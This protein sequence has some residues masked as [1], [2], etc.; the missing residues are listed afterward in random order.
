MNVKPKRVL[1]VGMTDN[2]GGIEALMLNA[3]AALDSRDIQFDFLANTDHMAFEEQLIER[4]SQVHRITA[5]RKSRSMFYRELNDLLERTRGTYD[6]IWENMNTL[7]NIDY[8]IHAKRYGIPVR[9]IHCHSS[10][11]C[12]GLVRGVLHLGNRRRIRKY[13][14]HFW[15]VSNEASE[16]FYG[17]DYKNLPN[18]RVI[19]NAIDSS[20][21]SFDGTK[22]ARVREAFG[23]ST[24]SLVLGNVGRMHAVKNQVVIVNTL[25]ELVNRGIDCSVVIV[26]GGELEESLR[27]RAKLLGVADR[28]HITGRVD[29]SAPYYSAMDVFMLPSLHEGLSIALLEA[30]ANGLPVAVSD[31]VLEDGVVAEDRKIVQL[32]SDPSEWADAVL[33]LADGAIGRGNPVAGTRFDLVELK[34]LFDGIF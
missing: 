2:P 20:R 13:A 28:L 16:W 31:H 8:L 27:S 10:Q 12:D 1:V 6:V 32:D 29:D 24:S 34:G 15:S 4:G 14:T 21:F 23:I 17:K 33:E 11:N 3:M 5:R 9:I 19:T 7:G 26:G 18:Y 25:A 30:Q 22:R